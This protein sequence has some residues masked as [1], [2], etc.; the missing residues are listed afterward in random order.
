LCCKRKKDGTLSGDLAT[1]EQFRMLKSYIF[2]VLQRMVDEIASGR[3][4]PNPYTRGTSHNACRFCPYAA[5]CHPDEVP[6]RRNYKTMSAQRF[7]E[8]IEKEVKRHG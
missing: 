2:L 3:V 5:V 4:A 1:A 6:D 8:E 7:W